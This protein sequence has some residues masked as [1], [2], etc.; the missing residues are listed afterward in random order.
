MNKRFYD[1]IFNLIVILVVMVTIVIAC[2]C[3]VQ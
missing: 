3:F 2:I 1:Y